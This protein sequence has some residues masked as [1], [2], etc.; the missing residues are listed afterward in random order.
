MLD[1]NLLE[2]FL[3]S[4]NYHLCYFKSCKSTM[5]PVDSYEHEN[6]GFEHNYVTITDNQLSGVGRS[7]SHWS[8]IPNTDLTFT[9]H[10]TL[11]IL[12]NQLSI[13]IGIVLLSFL[14]EQYLL[15]IKFKW[16]NDLYLEDKKLCGILI[17]NSTITN[18]HRF[19]GGSYTRCRIGIG[20]NVN[21]HHNNFISLQDVLGIIIDRNKLFCDLFYEVEKVLSNGNFR[22]FILHDEDDYLHGKNISLYSGGKKCIGVYAGYSENGIILKESNYNSIIYNNASNIEII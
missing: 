4:L 13:Y 11:N 3:S 22:D 7:G 9:I 16:P 18:K 8:S 21:S 14:K 6:Q 2:N 19:K 1:L 17:Q 12:P 20:I 5:S 15:P 10:K